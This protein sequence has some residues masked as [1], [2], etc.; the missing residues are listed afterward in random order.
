MALGPREFVEEVEK[1]YDLI[2]QKRKAKKAELNL[3]ANQRLKLSSIDV[4]EFE[5]EIFEI[6]VALHRLFI[7]QPSI[8]N[9]SNADT[10]KLLKKAKLIALAGLVASF[11]NY[12][13]KVWG[14]FWQFY[15]SEAGLSVNENFVERVLRPALSDEGLI[16]KKL[17]RGDS[18]EEIIAKESIFSESVIEDIY[19]GFNL[20]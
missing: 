1:Y 11:K 7:M 13:N 20:Y 3:S 4:S 10:E 14:H 15:G 6:T 17:D 8:N 18:L 5:N 19:Y 12:D 2:E 16:R 9:L